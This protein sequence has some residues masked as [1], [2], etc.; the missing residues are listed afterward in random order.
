MWMCEV[1]KIKFCGLL[2]G[3]SAPRESFLAL[4]Q[5]PRASLFYFP[6]RLASTPIPAGFHPPFRLA[7]NPL[8]RLASTP[9]DQTGIK[10]ILARGFWLAKNSSAV[11]IGKAESRRRN[12]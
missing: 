12:N 3:A 11:P 1:V 2:L 6:S 10:E 5:K 7:S 4:S 9:V 8:P